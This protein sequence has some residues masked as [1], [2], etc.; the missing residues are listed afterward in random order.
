VGFQLRSGRLLVPCDNKLAEAKPGEGPT[1]QSHVI[2][3]D[4]HGKSWQIGGVVGPGCNESQAVELD[5][6]TLMLNIRS[7]RDD[8][9]R[10]VALS[11]DGGQTFTD[12]VPDATLIDPN[13]QGSIVRAAGAGGELLF[14]NPASTK[15]EK[16]TVRF[17]RDGG[18]TWP[19]ATLLHAGPAAYSCLAVL[20]DG[21]VLCLYE[22]GVKHAYETITLAR[23]R[24]E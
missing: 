8:R 13:C 15:R 6:G 12:P 17:S 1:L 4:D 7:F 18:R 16:L 21:T 3:S 14:S 2:Y 24:R 5:D 10:L 9:R 19:D 22:R 20:A 11:K 23:F